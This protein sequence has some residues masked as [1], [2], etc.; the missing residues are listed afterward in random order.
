V[1]RVA[2]SIDLIAAADL[3]AEEAMAAADHREEI[4][5]DKIKKQSRECKTFRDCFSIK[6]ICKKIIKKFILVPG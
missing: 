1:L 4:L 3:M 2:D 6:N 5:T